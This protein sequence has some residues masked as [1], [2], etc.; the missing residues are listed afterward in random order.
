MAFSKTLAE[1]EQSVP[2]SDARK[3]LE[4]F[5]DNGEFTELDKFLSAEG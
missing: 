1:M 5:F 3:R 4:A 2:E